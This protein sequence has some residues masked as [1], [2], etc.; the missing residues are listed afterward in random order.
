[1]CLITFYN[2]QRT[3]K[4]CYFSVPDW[5]ILP[6]EAVYDIVNAFGNSFRLQ[7][8]RNNPK[9]YSKFWITQLHF[10]F[11][12]IVFV[13]CYRSNWDFWSAVDKRQFQHA[14][15]FSYKSRNIGESRHASTGP[16]KR[17][18]KSNF[19]FDMELEPMLIF[20]LFWRSFSKTYSICA[21][22]R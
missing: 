22:K 3:T 12:V 21:Q 20:R 5:L 8:E 18:G 1:M 15:I 16:N 10:H 17:S 11:G 9:S 4:P 14:I 13:Y 7:I 19:S 6:V 2:F